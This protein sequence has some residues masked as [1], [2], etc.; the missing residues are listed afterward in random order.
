MKS[1]SIEAKVEYS[2]LTVKDRLAGATSSSAKRSHSGHRGNEV[3]RWKSGVDA[4]G[5]EG[6]GGF[7][8]NRALA[9]LN[10]ATR[11][12]AAGAAVGR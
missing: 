1:V 2:F 3:G 8:K 7:G 6:Q 5:K 11:R 4:A 12:R 9:R 10:G